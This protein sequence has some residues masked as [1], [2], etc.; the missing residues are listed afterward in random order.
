MIEISGIDV[1][2][3][4]KLKPAKDQK[5]L[6]LRDLN[7]LMSAVILQKKCTWKQWSHMVS[8]LAGVHPSICENVLRAAAK[9]TGPELDEDCELSNIVN[10]LDPDLEF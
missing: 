5:K 4:V 10:N 3:K 8:L 9:I 6:V 2:A 1:K 7:G